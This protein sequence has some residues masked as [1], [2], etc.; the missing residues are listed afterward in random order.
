[1]KIANSKGIPLDLADRLQ[2]EDDE[3]LKKDADRLLAFIKPATGPGVP[4]PSNG[5]QGTNLDISNMFAKPP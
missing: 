3:A 1:M 4:P 2:G 5:G